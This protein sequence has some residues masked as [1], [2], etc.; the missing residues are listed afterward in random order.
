MFLPPDPRY[1]ID[2]FNHLGLVSSLPPGSP[3]AIDYSC[4]LGIVVLVYGLL[5]RREV[6]K[7]QL[8]S[9]WLCSAFLGGMYTVLVEGSVE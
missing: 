1:T 9:G 6:G 2:P 3:W 8:C 4:P 7:S 5:L